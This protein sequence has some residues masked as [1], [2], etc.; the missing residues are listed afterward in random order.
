M[1]EQAKDI[2]E[3]LT[4]MA[5]VLGMILEGVAIRWLLVDRARLLAKHD[6]LV[7]SILRAAGA[8]PPSS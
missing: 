5:P 1:K 2:V 7:S 6:E 4:I 8:G 3:A